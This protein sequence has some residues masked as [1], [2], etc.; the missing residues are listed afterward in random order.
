MH[1]DTCKSYMFLALDCMDIIAISLCI[2]PVMDASGVYSSSPLPT[3][4]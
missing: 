1:I 2:L 4:L 3:V